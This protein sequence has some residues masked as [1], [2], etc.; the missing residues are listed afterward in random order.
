MCLR[1]GRRNV[2]VDL[3]YWLYRFV[4]CVIIV[5]L[6]GRCGP[7]SRDFR[8]EEES[9]AEG[10]LDLSVKTDLVC[11]TCQ[12]D[13]RGQWEIV[14]V[15]AVIH[16]CR[17]CLCMLFVM[18]VCVCVCLYICVWSRSVYF[19]NARGNPAWVRAIGVFQSLAK[20]RE[21]KGNKKKKEK[22]IDKMT[23][24]ILQSA[25]RFHLIGSL[26]ANTVPSSCCALW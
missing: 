16:V 4:R 20:E 21:R 11:K 5:T 10:D 8:E 26:R 23:E 9:A 25:C 2:T 13:T 24:V 19:G 17:A 22:K 7:Q 12:N 6:P 3:G 14:L 15:C 1:Y 18:C